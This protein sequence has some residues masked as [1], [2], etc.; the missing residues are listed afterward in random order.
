MLTR[1]SRKWRVNEAVTGSSFNI[2]Q[3]KLRFIASSQ[4]ILAFTK[5]RRPSY[6]TTI[7]PFLCYKWRVSGRLAGVVSR[8]A[9]WVMTKKKKK[10]SPFN[11]PR[12]RDVTT[13]RGPT[14]TAPS[15]LPSSLAASCRR[16]LKA[17]STYSHFYGCRG[18]I[19]TRTNVK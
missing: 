7:F 6:F 12:P 9:K 10:L 16:F 18:L 19:T 17:D 11:P 5:H 8:P 14:V 15:L 3:L 1:R 13:G 2:W 4:I